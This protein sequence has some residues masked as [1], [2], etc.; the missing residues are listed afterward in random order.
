MATPTTT[1]T[2]FFGQD[3]WRVSPNLTVSYGLRYEI[4]PPFNDTTHQLGQFDRNFPGGRLIVQNEEVPLIS[5]S[6]RASVGS[7]RFIT[8]K[9]AG[10]PD[11]LRNTY[12]GNIQPRFGFNFDPYGGGKTVIKAHVGSYSVPVLGAVLYSLLGVDTSNYVTISNTNPTLPGLPIKGV[13]SIP[14]SA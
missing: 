8:A 3:D 2:V 5:P 6:W 13:S 4:N 14:A 7:T 11:T 12:Y 10:L 9:Q 1:T